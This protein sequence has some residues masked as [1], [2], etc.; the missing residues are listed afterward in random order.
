MT[1]YEYLRGLQEG[2]PAWLDQFKAGD[3]FP[4]RRFFGSRIVFYPGSGTDG[5]PVKLFGSTH[6][7]HCFVYADYGVPQ[8]VLEAELGDTGHHFLGYHSLSRLQLSQHDL[9]PNGWPMHVDA[10]D[11]RTNRHR[12]DADPSFAFLEVL[13]RDRG[14]D[15]NHGASRLAVLFL[16]A[17]GIATYS[18]LFC[19]AHRSPPF[20]ILLHD[21]GCG[22]N[23]DRFGKGGLLDRLVT[24]CRVFPRFLLVAEN[25][26]L[27]DGFV[28]ISEVAGDVGGMHAT[29]RLL[30]ESRAK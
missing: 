11:M 2:V 20:A 24:H 12:G 14:I 22:R 3:R 19:Q 13:Q 5:H 23:Y 1:P 25:T 8:T 27:W 28:R 7:A 18:A 15:N 21:H 9:V 26:K 4:R 10:N 30:C 6:S 17:D 16:G 29:V